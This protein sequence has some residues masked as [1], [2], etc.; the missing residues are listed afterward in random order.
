MSVPSTA[1]SKKITT[2]FFFF[3][4]KNYIY[5][6]NNFIPSPK[7]FIFFLCLAI[8]ETFWWVKRNDSLKK[9]CLGENN[10]CSTRYKKLVLDLEIFFVSN[11]K[12]LTNWKDTSSKAKYL[13]SFI[14]RYWFHFSETWVRKHIS[15]KHF[16]M[17]SLLFIK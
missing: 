15:I 5:A 7:Y 1:S 8:K 13:F 17:L 10:S 3:K 16:S 2:F 12:D 9:M 6:L 14:K 4:K 11:F